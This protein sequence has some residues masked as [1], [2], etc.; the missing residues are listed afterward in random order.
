M[1]QTTEVSITYK[2]DGVQTLF[3]YPYP[4]RS[5]EDI[6]G[7]I[8]DESGHEERITTNFKY[9]N[10][11]NMYQYPPRRGSPGRAELPQTDSR[12]TAA[13]ERRPSGQAAVF[14][15]RKEPGLDHY[16]PPGNRQ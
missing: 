7:Y 16:D 6:V 9:D 14:S 15:H 12:N 2:G 3:S 8:V 11:T 10:V 5:S 4:Y 13:A 1:I